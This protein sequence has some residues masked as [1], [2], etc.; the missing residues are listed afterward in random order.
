MILPTENQ[1]DL[2]ELPEDICKEMEFIFAD[3][4]QDVLSAAIPTLVQH[5]AALAA[6]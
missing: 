2:D 6:M 4:I 1:K 5:T 3:K